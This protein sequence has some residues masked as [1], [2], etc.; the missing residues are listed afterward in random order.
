M[1][2]APA[3][4]ERK[5]SL[6]E[7]HDEMS[8]THEKLYKLSRRTSADSLDSEQSKGECHEPGAGV[9]PAVDGDAAPR[10]DD[11][12]IGVATVMDDDHDDHH[13]ADKDGGGAGVVRG[14]MNLPNQ[15]SED[16]DDR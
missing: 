10:H 6:S 1:G 15:L 3:P 7:N 4:S 5:I 9:G 12:M 8:R 16:E 2:G 14:K 11:V 13:A